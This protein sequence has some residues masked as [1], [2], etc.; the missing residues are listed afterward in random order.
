MRISYLLLISILAFTSSAWATVDGDA[1]GD[2]DAS[3]KAPSTA[4]AGINPGD[5]LVNITSG[6]ASY[7]IGIEIP[8]GAGDFQPSLSL[9]FTEG[10]G[11]RGLGQGW[12][13]SGAYT[14]VRRGPR[15][16]VPTY[17]SDDI[18]ILD[19]PVASGELIPD[20]GTQNKFQTKINSFED[21]RADNGSE[22]LW[23]IKTRSGL[24]LKFGGTGGIFTRLGSSNFADTHTWGLR[25]IEDSFGNTISY[26]WNNN[27]G[28]TPTLKSIEYSGGK[29][30]FIYGT[31]AYRRISYELGTRIDNTKLLTDI[32]VLTTS[33]AQLR[34]F[35]L[36]YNDVDSSGLPLSPTAP[37]DPVQV[38]Y[39]L[40]KV[41]LL[42]SDNLAYSDPWT[43]EYTRRNL[44]EG[45]W[46]TTPVELELPRASVRRGQCSSGAE[47]ECV[48]DQGTRFAEINGDGL[49]DLV[50]AS[51][52]WNYAGDW[53][54]DE[55]NGIYLNEGG[56][57]FSDTPL[58]NSYIPGN[59]VVNWANRVRRSDYG[60]S[61]GDL[62]GD[63]K[64]EAYRS[65]LHHYGGEG[66]FWAPNT[67]AETQ[68][69]TIFG[70][71]I[72]NTINSWTTATYYSSNFGVADHNLG[73][74]FSDLNNDGLT[75]YLQLCNV[76]NIAHNGSYGWCGRDEI[77]TTGI[78]KASA[79][80]DWMKIGDL[81]HI[82]QGVPHYDT[83]NPP[84]ERYFSITFSDL[85]T[86]NNGIP[87][88][89]FTLNTSL[90]L[91]DVNGD[92]LPD[93]VAFPDDNL[94]YRQSQGAVGKV[95]FNKDGGS[96][97]SED[98]PHPVSGFQYLT[99]S[100]R[101]DNGR[102]F[103][104][105]NM[106]GLVDILVSNAATPEE[107]GCYLNKGFTPSLGYTWATQPDQSFLTP[108]PVVL[109]DPTF[110]SDG[111]ELIDLDGDGLLDVVHSV[112]RGY[113][114]P[115]SKLYRGIGGVPGLLEEV[116]LPTGGVQQF[117]H[118]PS[119]DPSIH[120]WNPLKPGLA[121]PKQLVSRVTS[122][123]NV[124]EVTGMPLTT[125]EYM[126]YNGLYQPEE[127]AFYGFA[128]V[129]VTSNPSNVNNTRLVEDNWFHQDSTDLVGKLRY[130]LTSV[131]GG[132]TI[133]PEDRLTWPADAISFVE[134]NFV[135]TRTQAPFFTP[136]SSAYQE[137]FE[138]DTTD[139][140]RTEK[141][142][143]HNPE[144]GVVTREFHVGRD[145]PSPKMIQHH[146]VPPTSEGWSV[147]CQTDVY[148][149][150]AG[151]YP[152]EPNDME[153]ELLVKTA[154]WYT[155]GTHCATI[156]NPSKPI[157]KIVYGFHNQDTERHQWTQYD[158]Y[159]NVIC[160]TDDPIG[161]T[162]DVCQSAH[163]FRF[164]YRTGGA[165]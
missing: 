31:R 24:T 87:A 14:I 90:R 51:A 26:F 13:L 76:K 46:S 104:D 64:A 66:R 34:A 50:V 69:G 63:G 39:Y 9:N 157:G 113:G 145:N 75:D 48:I 110:K 129:T 30:S 147:E 106:D 59:F 32:R 5:D 82:L 42:G 73:V 3:V 88:T 107:N 97:F 165:Y 124:G 149:I 78:Y 120:I 2:G 152:F 29:I 83:Q 158:Q 8:R 93:L 40:T 23:T 96:D 99:D 141:V 114:S 33:G 126:Y 119:T 85:Y 118:L 43:F 108:V 146:Y 35:K 20:G 45:A 131:S 143:Y 159:G 140:I 37:E 53:N 105:C 80:G 58:P 101:Q 111:V 109:N 164:E 162:G 86:N 84:T 89:D 95:Y 137:A 154:Y 4:S 36:S 121:N 161:P 136:L 148:E 41:Q 134:Q 65:S 130:K 44:A 139:S 49:P 72:F 122:D 52:S 135:R 128:R 127:R 155:Q 102:R 28:T 91:I 94:Q 125:T 27:S 138:G 22:N 12:S 71:P 81:D 70:E 62:D 16:S 100:H 15:H 77:N 103:V 6:Q 153:T 11:D 123:P 115:I 68:G 163:A 38:N 60:F 54:A 142:F 79:P 57:L 61:L 19:S 25:S 133:D 117:H 116:T 56:G 160:Q 7:S 144:Q 18:F 10:T 150:T 92:A 67:F 132:R 47:G 21:I 55:G 74:S 98:S 17:T 112:D 1:D 151:A 156:D